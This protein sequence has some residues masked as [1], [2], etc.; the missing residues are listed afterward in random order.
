M[1]SIDSSEY[2]DILKHM[3]YNIIRNNDNILIIKINRNGEYSFEFSELIFNDVLDMIKN[4][5][6]DVL[7]REISYER[8]I[9]LLVLEYCCLVEDKCLD[10]ECLDINE[11]INYLN[12]YYEYQDYIP[13]YQTTVRFRDGFMVCNVREQKNVYPGIIDSILD[14]YNIPYTNTRNF[15]EYNMMEVAYKIRDIFIGISERFIPILRE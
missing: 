12:F 14:E 3:S 4:K 9:E 7:F 15:E 13:G 8:I 6:G 1:N 11:V 5:V 2:N 10:L